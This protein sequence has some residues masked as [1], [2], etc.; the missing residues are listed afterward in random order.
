M[1]L[2]SFTFPESIL[3]KFG[4]FLS[5]KAKGFAIASKYLFLVSF[6]VSPMFLL[7]YIKTRMIITANGAVTLEKVGK[8]PLTT[9]LSREQ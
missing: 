7:N 4:L 6:A 2:P 1:L 8:A 5:I 3:A 9:E